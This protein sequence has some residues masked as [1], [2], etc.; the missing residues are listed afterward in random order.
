MELLILQNLYIFSDDA[1]NFEN[2]LLIKSE[3]IQ[4]VI[5]TL[6]GLIPLLACV[7]VFIF[8]AS[9]GYYFTAA[10]VIKVVLL[11]LERQ[12]CI[13]DFENGTRSFPSWRSAKYE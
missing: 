11:R 1:S 2:R 6:F 8:Q 5:S 3:I 13:K 9:I 4:A 12:L 10:Q 7:A